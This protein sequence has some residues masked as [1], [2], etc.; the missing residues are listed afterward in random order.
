MR[1]IPINSR[2]SESGS[3]EMLG[4][5]FRASGPIVLVVDKGHYWVVDHDG[6]RVDADAPL[7]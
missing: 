1:V 4:S 6:Q 3:G 5:G 7:S 2:G